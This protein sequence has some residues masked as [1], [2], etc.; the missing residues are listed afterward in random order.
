VIGDAHA[1]SVGWQVLEDLVAVGDRSAGHDGE[2]EG[3][4]VVAD[5]FEQTGFDDVTIDE[6]DVPGWWRGSSTLSVRGDVDRRFEAQHEVIALPGTPDGSVNTDLVDVGHGLPREFDEADLDGK[7][8]VARSDVP[9]GHDRW[10][11]RME[12]YVRAVNAGAA[13]FVFRN[14][15]PG[16]LPATGEVGYQ[17]RPGPI[18]AVGVSAEVG[19][20]LERACERGSATVAL[21]VDCRN[22]PAVSRNVEATVGP[23]TDR[24][25]LVSAH[26]DAHDIVE[27]AEDN[28]FGSALVVEVGRL[29]QQ[30]ADDLDTRVRLVVFGA[31]EIGLYGARHWTATRDLDAVDAVVNVDGA[32]YSRNLLVRTNGFDAVESVFETVTDRLDAP[33]AVAEGVSPHGDQWAFVEHGVPGVMAKSDSGEAGRGWGHTHA[34]TIDKLDSRDLRDLAVL[35]ASATLALADERTELPHKSREDVQALIGEGHETEL[36]TRGAWPYE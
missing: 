10:I 19:G 1:N 32:G 14:H 11:H 20:F 6:F 36:R 15:V 8:A 35:L 34:D 2:R 16:C 27:G 23:D 7:V 4:H 31:E 18:P 33:L 28:A 21:D 5:W 29:L 3:A 17:N 30:V 25:V 9:D 12:K 26:V 13:G 22:A 24:E